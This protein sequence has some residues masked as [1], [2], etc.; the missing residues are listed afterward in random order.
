MTGAGR[1]SVLVAT[2]GNPDRG[3]D[4]LGPAVG[5]RLRRRVPDAARVIDCGGD[6]LNLIEAWDGFAAAIVVDAGARMGR[7]GTVHRLDLMSGSP[8]IASA[9]G[10]THSFGLAEVVGIARSLGR[11]PRLLVVYLVEGERFDIGAPLSPPVA[12]AVERV[13]Q[14]IVAEIARMSAER[15]EGMAE[16][17]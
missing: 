14:N 8:L 2:I 15:Q 4:G 7:P 10:S 11:L 1:Q 3:D 5:N 13:A 12:D 6:V 17:A 9:R 16:H